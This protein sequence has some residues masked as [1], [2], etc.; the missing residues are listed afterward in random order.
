MGAA[1]TTQTDSASLRIAAGLERL[2]VAFRHAA[3]Q[4]AGSRNVTPT[5]DQALAYLAGRG[6]AGCRLGELSA[7]LALTEATMSEVV[8][9]LSLKGLVQKQRDPRDGRALRLRLTAEGRG[10]A[11]EAQR[12]PGFMAAALSG[13]ELREQALLLRLLSKLM[14]ELEQGGAIP[15]QRMCV[16]CRAFR[17]N[18]HDSGQQPHHCSALDFAFGDGELRLDCPD[19]APADGEQARDNWFEFTRYSGPGFPD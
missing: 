1:Y 11:A 15:A 4:A 18:L 10:Q 5:Q 16:S 6:A 17:P 3:W 19:H 2:G 8:R 14:R 9:S 12:W 13:L 7:A